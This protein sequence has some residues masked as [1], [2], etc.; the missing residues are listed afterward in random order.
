MPSPLGGKVDINNLGTV[1]D[2]MGVKLSNLELRDL[3]QNM[4]VGGEYLI[5]YQMSPF[6][7]ITIIYLH[8]LRDN[9]LGLYACGTYQ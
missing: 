1:L 7:C 3:K 9:S 8:R 6:L 2:N 5:R 4:Q